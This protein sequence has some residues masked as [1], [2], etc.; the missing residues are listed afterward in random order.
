MVG[1]LLA[2][3]AFLQAGDGVRDDLDRVGVEQPEVGPPGI[4]SPGGRTHGTAAASS[5]RRK[6]LTSCLAARPSCG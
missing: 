4:S 5:A 2:V 6:R 1:R 3:G